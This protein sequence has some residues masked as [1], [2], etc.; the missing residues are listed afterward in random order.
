M[1][2]VD[3]MAEDVT[4]GGGFGDHVDDAEMNQSQMF[5][6]AHVD[7]PVV[8]VSEEAVV[9]RSLMPCGGKDEELVHDV[10]VERNEAAMMASVEVAVRENAPLQLV[11]DSTGDDA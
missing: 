4:E 2:I 6:E 9:D 7:E 1:L 5:W 3:E 11:V 8:A 10:A